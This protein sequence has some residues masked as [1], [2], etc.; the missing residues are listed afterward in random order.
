[1]RHPTTGDAAT[2]GGKYCAKYVRCSEACL[3]TVFV[4]MVH[5]QIDRFVCRLMLEIA[6]L[7]NIKVCLAQWESDG[8]KCQLFTRVPR[9]PQVLCSIHRADKILLP[10]RKPSFVGR[11]RLQISLRHFELS[12]GFHVEN[13]V[14][15]K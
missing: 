12:W 6:G 9:L 3:S 8:L 1:M 14:A 13:T 11:K 4:D 7:A 10:T 5:G 15:R 2:R